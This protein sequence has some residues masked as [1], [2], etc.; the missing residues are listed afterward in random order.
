MRSAVDQHTAVHIFTHCIR[1]LLRDKAVIWVTHQL[2]LLP[3]VHSVAVMDA[4]TVTYF[5]A[6]DPDVSACFIKRTYLGAGHFIWCKDTY[7]TF[8]S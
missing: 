3:H 8:E 5:G 1:G 6:Y 4:G 7:D 2:D